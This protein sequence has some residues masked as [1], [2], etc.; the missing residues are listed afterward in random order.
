MARSQFNHVIIGANGT[1]KTTFSF[2]VAIEYLNQDHRKRILFIVPDDSEEKLD[3]I[4]EISFNQIKNFSGVKKFVAE[5]EKIF[6][7]FLEIFADREFKF[8]GLII[9]DDLGVILS[10]R[11]NPVLRLLKR[12]RQ[13]NIDFLWSFHGL[14]C[15]VPPSFY[16]YVNNIYLFSTSDNHEETLKELPH[17]KKDSFENMYFRVQKEAENK[18]NYFEELIINPI[19][20]Y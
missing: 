6:D 17:N 16:T 5:N 14:R 1:G 9:C 10:R 3:N 4:E 19:K 15:E 7:K 13:S 12:R 18:F 11:P 8:N 2:E 20:N